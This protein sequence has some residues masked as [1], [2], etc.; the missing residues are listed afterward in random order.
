VDGS[1][2][3]YVPVETGMFADGKVEINGQGIG[4]GT[5]VGVPR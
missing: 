4:A 2:T 3:R 1:S 5:V